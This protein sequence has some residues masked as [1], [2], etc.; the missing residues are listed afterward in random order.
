MPFETILTSNDVEHSGVED[1]WTNQS[2]K[3]KA[4]ERRMGDVEKKHA[5]IKVII[6]DSKHSQEIC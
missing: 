5:D 6:M 3:D 4:T 1:R 2:Q